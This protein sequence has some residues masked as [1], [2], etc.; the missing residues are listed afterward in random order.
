M[1]D[2]MGWAAAEAPKH[3]NFVLAAGV[4]SGTLFALVMALLAY[5]VAHP[6]ARLLFLLF[7]VCSFQDALPYAFWNSVF[8][9]PPGDFGRILLD[10]QDEWLRWTCVFGFGFAYLAAT[11]ACN[12][13]IFRNLQSILGATTNAHIAIV[14]YGLIG[15]GGGVAWFGFDWNQ[16]IEDVGRIPQ[17]VGAGLQLAMAPLL[18]AVRRR[19]IASTVSP[20]G[21]TLAIAAAWVTAAISLVVLLFRLQHGVY[22]AAKV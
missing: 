10:L 22:W 11:V 4:I 19:E 20:L 16:V 9:R 21:W 18:M 7:A 12:I 13:A 1:P 2:G 15:L 3:Q 8:P 14:A 17:F 5:R 6:L